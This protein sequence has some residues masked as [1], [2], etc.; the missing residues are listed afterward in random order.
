MQT[1]RCRDKLFAAGRRGE[2]V[3]ARSGLRQGQ[4]DWNTGKVYFLWRPPNPARRGMPCDCA[5]L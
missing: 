3:S 5:R 1:G 2:S 4:A